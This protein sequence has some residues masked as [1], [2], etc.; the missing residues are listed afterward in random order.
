MSEEEEEQQQP[1]KPNVHVKEA[2]NAVIIHT[3]DNDKREEANGT[4]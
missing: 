3:A 1:V 4:A 2:V